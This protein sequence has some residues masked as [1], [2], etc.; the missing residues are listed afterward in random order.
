MSVFYERQE[1]LGQMQ[2]C[3]RNWSG[4]AGCSLTVVAEPIGANCRFPKSAR[5]PF[6]ENYETWDVAFSWEMGPVE[7]CEIL[8]GCS[9]GV[10]WI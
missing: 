2:L 8:C 10:G 9:G 3:T 1:V 5:Q 4:S 6:I 7:T